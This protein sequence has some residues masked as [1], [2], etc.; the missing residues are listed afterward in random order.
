MLSRHLVHRHCLSRQLLGRSSQRSASSAAAVPDSADVVVIGGGAIGCSTLY[1][2]SAMGVDAILL[3]KDQITAGTTW[4]S[5][6]LLWR[7]RPNDTE[8]KLIDRTREL[9]RSGGILEQETGA[10][11]GWNSNGGLFIASSAE[12]LAE[13]Q[14]LQTI[15]KCFGIESEVLSPAESQEL[16]PLLNVDDVAGTLFSPG[17]G[18]VEPAEYVST[19]SRAAKKRGARIF[20]NAA[21]S[22]VD[23]TTSAS[24]Q[25]SA[26]GVV[27]ANGQR[28]AARKVIICGGVWSRDFAA[29]SGIRIPLCAMKHAYVL[30]A[31]IE[32]IR[33]M[34]CVRDHDLSVYLRVQGECLQ[35]GGYEQNPVFWDEV[36]E[37]FAFGLFDL[38][39]DVFSVHLENGVRRVPIIGS[40][41]IKTEVCGPESFTAD[42]K[43][44]LGPVPEC[45]DN[46]LF[47]G[48]GFNSAGIMLSGGCGQQLARWMVEGSPDLDVFGYDINRFHPALSDHDRWIRERSHESYAKNYSI[49]FPMDEPLAARNMRCSP[50]HDELLR[51]GCVF[52]ERH[53]FERPAWFALGD[54]TAIRDYDFYG[55]YG[56][57]AH[58]QYEYRDRLD[59]EYS[60]EFAPNHSTIGEEVRACRD[61]VAVFD[62]SY[63]GKFW[64][65]G[66]DALSALQFL[67]T[68]N[69]EKAV[70]AT[71]YTQMLNER[72]GVEC[73]LAVHRVADDRF[74][75]TAGGGS[76]SHDFKHIAA[77]ILRM[78]FDCALSDHSED[79]AMLSVMGPLSR[80]TLY[81]LLPNG[82]RQRGALENDAFPFATNQ[83]IELLGDD[84]AFHKLRAIRLTFV[85]ELGWE[86]HIPRESAKAVY[87]S[88]IRAGQEYGIRNAGY[89]AIDSLSCEKGYLHWHEDVGL[90]D[91][92]LEAG[93]GFVVS[94]K[95]MEDDAV[96]FA[97]KQALRRQKKEGLRKRLVYVAVLDGSVRIHGLETLWRNGTH[98]VGYLRRASFDYTRNLSIGTGYIEHHEKGGVVNPKYIRGDGEPDGVFYEIEVMGKRYPCEVSVKA[99]FDPK[100][101]RIH[102]RYDLVAAEAK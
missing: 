46:S 49:V 75:I 42:H 74:Y 39:W 91:T 51:N 40:T 41:G 26:N 5:A 7:L 53:G 61:S 73:D 32:G 96:D 99:Q 90:F 95:K 52:Q 50:I 15:G 84:G 60:F 92:P 29:K 80:E 31:G 98:C 17:D 48:A 47:V 83:E 102:G 100:N 8:I 34:P 45:S 58:R 76:Y 19:L 71:T 24:G 28:V 43:P 35:V 20:E 86:L 68:N 97:G 36:E 6:G 21:V 82:E 23:V 81:K 93:V 79:F 44:L 94:K 14:R 1:H 25:R 89:R 56:Y 72:G 65:C 64:L 27:L 33:T 30:T 85:G 69:V 77:T 9:V 3:E 11:S 13:Y 66:P 101:D 38:D 67:C 10:T 4:H 37:D 78:G 12:R 2:L 87:A 16:Y 62:Q 57:G 22:A 59:D 54:D 70:G 55:Q 18:T 88:I 63:F